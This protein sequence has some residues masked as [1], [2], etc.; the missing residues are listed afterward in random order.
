MDMIEL[1]GT[2]VINQ[3]SDLFI[4]VD[5]PPLIKVEG[6]IRPTR[7]ERL[8]SEENHKLI[9][10]ILQEKD[11]AEFKANHELNIALKLE[12]IGRFRVNVFQ[13]MGEPAMVVRYIKK[14]IPSIEDLGLPE[15]LKELI[16]YERGLILLVGS[17]GTGKS[18]TLASMIDHRNTHQSGHILTIEDPIEFIHKNKQ[19]LVNQREV[20]VDTSS[21]EI[22]LKNAMREAPDVI[23]IGEIRDRETMKQA[24][25]YA[26][27]GHLCLATL[28]ANSANLALERI[29]NFF[30]EEAHRV[31]LQDIS[32]NLR[33]IVAQRLCIG[34]EQRRVA[35]VEL[36]INTPFI[37]QLIEKGRIEDIKEAMTRSKGRVN[38][39][40]DE[41]L[42]KL[43]KQGSISRKE[44]L[45]KAD[46][47]NNLSVKF[48][49]ED[50][51]KTGGHGGG[52]E[53]VINDSAPFDHYH[54][55][56][57]SPL[58]V[59]AKR[60]DTKKRINTALI[61]ALNARGLEL[62]SQDADIDVQYVLGLKVEESLALEAI[63]GQQNNFKHFIPETKEQAMLVINVMDN[64]NKKPIF[65]IT[66]VRQ[67]NDFNEN[68]A[69]LNKGIAMLLAKLPVG[70]E[71]SAE[72]TSSS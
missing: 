59:R 68:Q 38:Q 62:K 67:V 54:T 57:I 13:Q 10:S 27:T 61:S 63:E 2:M 6:K 24:L 28:H 12:R 65:R 15:V 60:A 49:L 64:H 35:A 33:A 3:A 53:F 55:F 46:S 30:P 39:T 34:L 18:T 51:D 42:Y 14:K 44:A 21:F 9:Y 37:A 19:S 26:E 43:V 47:A 56:S 41:A 29:I 20:G 16:S 32:L 4:S 23:L 22:A 25:T 45:R 52:S 7:E 8:T 1:L 58:T 17:T 31:I 50:G 48:R 69:Q 36:M 5:S 11:V 71:H 40:F 66:A 70:H 72:S